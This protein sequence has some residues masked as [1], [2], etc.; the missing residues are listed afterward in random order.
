MKISKTNIQKVT[1]R[2]QITLP[3]V[4]RDENEGSLVQVEIRDG[5]L[6]VRPAKLDSDDEVVWSAARDNNGKGID[7]KE[8]IK[9]LQGIIDNK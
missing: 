8:F 9:L 5:S 1:T 3:K 4:W 7:D 6:V 2:G